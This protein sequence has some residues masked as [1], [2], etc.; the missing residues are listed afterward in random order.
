MPEIQMVDLYHQYHKIKHEI[1]KAVQEVLNSC[2]F[3]KGKQVTDFENALAAY[4]DC[5]HVIS[6]GNGTDALQLALMAL[7]LEAGAEVIVPDFTF[8]APAE[9]VAITGHTPV[10]A[11]VDEHTFNI[12][13]ASVKKKIT[14]KT[15]AIIV[16]H[17]FGQCADMEEIVKIAKKHNLFIIEDTAQALGTALA[18]SD[19]LTKKAG[20][21]GHLGCTSFFPSKNLGAYGDGGAVFCN[22]NK[23]AENVRTIANHGTMKKYYHHKVGVNSRLDTLQAAILNVKLNY[24]DDYHKARQKAAAYYDN[25]LKDQNNVQIPFR[26]HKSTHIY[27]QYT[28]KI[29]EKRNEL[30]KYFKEN[31]IPTAIYY[32]VP[33]HQQ[34]PYIK[35]DNDFPVSKKL[36]R[37]VLS[38]PMHTELTEQQ[39]L[40]ITT[41]INNFF[42]L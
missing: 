10:L 39:L 23:L 34:A 38:I 41:C 9:A 8:V 25:E 26:Y 2:R 32:P 20:T 27:H 28:L 37:E 3:I 12:D 42:E 35:S 1:D 15:R 30:K 33:I 11:D 40:Y 22:N 14:T 19:G 4:L 36:S 17:L 21:I 16:V 13:P 5:K 31:A 6:C 24:L 7:E 18:F 29:A